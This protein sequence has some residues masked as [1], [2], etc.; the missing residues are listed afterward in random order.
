MT[1]DTTLAAAVVFATFAGPIPAVLITRWIDKRRAERERQLDIFRALMRTR[2]AAIQPDHVNALNLVEIEFHN[3]QPV[4]TA[5]RDLT[6]H[7]NVAAAQTHAL[8]PASR[9]GAPVGL[10]FACGKRLILGERQERTRFMSEDGLSPLPSARRRKGPCSLRR[11]C[12]RRRRQR[13]H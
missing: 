10:L 7:I 11:R 9:E 5:Y 12:A 8:A 4:L 2:R 13:G 1:T 3:V 6:S